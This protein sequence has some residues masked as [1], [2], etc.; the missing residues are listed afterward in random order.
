MCQIWS[1]FTSKFTIIEPI[2]KHKAAFLLLIFSI[3]IIVGFAC[4]AGLDMGFNKHHHHDEEAAISAE[5]DHHHEAKEEFEHHHNLGKEH[6][7]SDDNCCNK[8]VTEFSQ[9]DKLLTHL[10]A[11]E[12]LAPGVFI[13]PVF[14]YLF[15]ISTATRKP[16]LIRVFRNRFSTFPDI[17]VSIQSFQ[18]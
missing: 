16:T 15:D 18:I 6:K 8:G 4:A 7:E 12:T 17:R 3:N 9:S 5:S 14:Y 13:R 1:N 2:K 11:V 10:F